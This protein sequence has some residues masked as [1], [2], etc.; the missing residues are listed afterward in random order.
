MH[1]KGPAAFEQMKSRAAKRGLIDPITLV[2]NELD[3]IKLHAVMYEKRQQ[4]AQLL[5]SDTV[6]NER[7]QEEEEDEIE[8]LTPAT[9]QRRERVD[10]VLYE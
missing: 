2:T 7:N 8:V 3:A 1:L 4:R 6:A 5:L 10:Q 9:P